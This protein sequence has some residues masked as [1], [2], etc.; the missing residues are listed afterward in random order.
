MENSIET[1]KVISA[2]KKEFTDKNT[3]EKK[4]YCSVTGMST[5]NE[6]FIFNDY[7]ETPEN[8]AVYGMYL[9]HDKYLKA[10]IIYKR[11]K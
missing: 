4:L 10:K 7:N 11:L 8:D 1:L 5:H 2:E 9:T 6:V 3:G